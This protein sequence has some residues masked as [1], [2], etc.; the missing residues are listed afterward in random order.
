M[1]FATT[2]LLGEIAGLTIFLGLPVARQ[3]DPPGPGK[4]SSTPWRPAYS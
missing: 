4:P 2:I 1:S 3:R